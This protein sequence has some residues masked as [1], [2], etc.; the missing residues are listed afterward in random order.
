MD[1][2]PL[3]GRRHGDPGIFWKTWPPYGRPLDNYQITLSFSWTCYDFTRPGSERNGELFKT[4]GLVGTSDCDTLIQKA[5]R[6]GKPTM[7]K[8]F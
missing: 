7:D 5:A 3:S 4:I 1:V 8:T 2:R 6:S